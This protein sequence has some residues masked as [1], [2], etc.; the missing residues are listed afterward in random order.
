MA[1]R[2]PRI[3]TQRLRLRPPR[4]RDLDNWA[5]TVF[6]D[7]E[8][9]RYMPKRD[10][11]PRA[12]AERA[13]AVYDGL[14]EKH[15]FGGWLITQKM[16]GALLGHCEL[17]YLEETD[18]VEL[19]YALGRAHWGKGLA[20][21]AARAAV[22]F[23]FKAAVFRPS[24]PSSPKMSPRIG[25]LSTSASP[26]RRRPATMIW[27]SCTIQL[28]RG[29]SSMKTPCFERPAESPTRA[30]LRIQERLPGIGDFASPRKHLV[31]RPLPGWAPREAIHPT[32]T[33]V[34]AA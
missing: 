4:E 3:E 19:G 15:G 13:K 28:R 23:G 9:V 8:V 6:G 10:M 29:S 30:V 12:R 20:T 32:P 27:R 22:R 33:A 17:E 31:R 14:W 7:P 24:W 26:M 5:V 16:T 2:F 1:G 11:T 25:Y 34:L 18:E 21:E